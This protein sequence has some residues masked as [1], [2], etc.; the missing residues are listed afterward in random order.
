MRYRVIL[1]LV[2]QFLNGVLPSPRLFLLSL[3]HSRRASN[4]VRNVI[5]NTMPL[6]ILNPGR[7]RGPRQLSSFGTSSHPE[8]QCYTLVHRTR[9]NRAQII[10]AILA[11]FFLGPP[12]QIPAPALTLI[13]TTPTAVSGNQIYSRFMDA[14]LGQAASI[15]NTARHQTIQ[16]RSS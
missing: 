14:R 11:T 12:T 5:S 9:P 3:P 16:F 4:G 13:S 7:V 8:S 10:L 6:R 15:D 1:N 2:S